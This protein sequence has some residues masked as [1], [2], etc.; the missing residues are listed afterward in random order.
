[1]HM[2]LFLEWAPADIFGDSTATAA[3]PPSKTRSDKVIGDVDDGDAEA[4]PTATLFVKNLNFET[5]SD[6]LEATF[7]K[8]V[9]VV[10]SAKVRRCLA[11]GCANLF[12]VESNGVRIR[13]AL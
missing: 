5:T 12:S 8:R 11:K 13:T 7:R 3:A 1:M 9:N 6:V 4:E 10:R 2:P